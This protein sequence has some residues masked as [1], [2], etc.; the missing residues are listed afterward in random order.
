MLTTRREPCDMTEQPMMRRSEADRQ[1]A[2]WRRNLPRSCRAFRARPAGGERARSRAPAL[3]RRRCRC[4]PIPTARR[5]APAT[6]PR[7]FTRGYIE[8]LFKTADTPLGARVRRRNRRLFRR[9]S[10]RVL[11]RRRG[12][13]APTADRRR[14][15]RCVRWCSSSVRSTPARDR[16]SP[17]SP[18]CGSSAARWPKA[19]FSCSPTAPRTRS[20]SSAGSAHPERRAGLDRSGRRCPPTLPKRPTASCDF[21]DVRPSRRRSAGR[22]SSIAAGLRSSLKRHSRRWCRRSRCRGCR[23]WAPTRSGSRRCADAEELMDRARGSTRAGPARRWSCRFRR[24][25]GVG[26]WLFAENAAD[27]PWRAP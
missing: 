24:R 21:A 19:A 6:S 5:P 7:M 23:S 3:R 2:G 15:S 22:S 13:N 9:A 10:R 8:V 18:W 16:A 27:L 14:L 20:G 1:L 26:A 12:G 17:P 25:L 11:G 4:S